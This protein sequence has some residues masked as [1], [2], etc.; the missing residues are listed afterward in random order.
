MA[1]SIWH[2]L[3][4]RW[5]ALILTLVVL[6]ATLIM[7]GIGGLVARAEAS[8]ASAGVIAQNYQ[9]Q[10]C[11]FGALWFCYNPR[12]VPQSCF[13]GGPGIGYYQCS[14]TFVQQYVVG[15]LRHLISGGP[16]ATAW[17]AAAVL[18]AFGLGGLALSTLTARRMRVWSLRRLYPELA[19]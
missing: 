2:D 4:A 3:G 13:D 14:G 18:T 12:Y 7:L 16:L 6:G 1:K 19:V 8:A 15:G 5:V 10:E 9:N 17:Q 11:G